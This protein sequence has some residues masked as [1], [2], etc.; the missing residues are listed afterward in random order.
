MSRRYKT[1]GVPDPGEPLHCPLCG[2]LM[3]LVFSGKRSKLI[4]KA[5]YKGAKKNH[6]YKYCCPEKACGFGE[7]H[8]K[9]PASRR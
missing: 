1:K 6:Q 7:I 3:E 5:D 2:K 4:K 9:A 8:M